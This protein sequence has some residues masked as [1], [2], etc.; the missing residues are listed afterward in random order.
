MIL[1]VD[2]GNTR[3]KAA[4]LRGISSCNILF[5]VDEESEKILKIF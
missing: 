5:F 3:I 1:V 2:V 4:V